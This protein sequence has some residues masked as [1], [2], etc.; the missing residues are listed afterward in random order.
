MFLLM[1]TKPGRN[2]TEE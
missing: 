1:M 2:M